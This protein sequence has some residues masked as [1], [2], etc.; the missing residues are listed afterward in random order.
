MKRKRHYVED[1]L[2][3]ESSE[4]K[5]YRKYDSNMVTRKRPELSATNK[6]KPLVKSP[7]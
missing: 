6:K 5:E 2:L 1:Q 3:R 4:M 7:V